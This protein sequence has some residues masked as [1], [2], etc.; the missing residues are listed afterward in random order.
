M[1]KPSDITGLSNIPKF[2]RNR[3][4]DG[5]KRINIIR[6]LPVS[7]KGRNF[8]LRQKLLGLYDKGNAGTVIETEMILLDKDSEELYVSI[9]G[10][11]FAI[12]QGN[13]G[14]PKGMTLDVLKGTKPEITLQ[15]GPQVVNFSVPRDREPDFTSTQNTSNET[16]L[17]YR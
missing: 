8:E 15:L 12:G 10:S 7:S 11:V 4:V 16:P 13:W 3:I 5:Q 14:G 1:G 17:L 6:P 2:D 9:V